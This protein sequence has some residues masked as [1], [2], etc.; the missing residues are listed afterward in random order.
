MTRKQLFSA[1]NELCRDLDNKY[2]INSGGCCYIAAIIA[3]N[4]EEYCIP[5]K[6]V[7]F[8][9]YGTHYAIMVSD[10]RLNGAKWPFRGFDEIVE[11]NSSRLFEIYYENEWNEVYSTEHNSEVNE[12]ISNLF[13]KYGNC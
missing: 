13:K 6:V 4:L 2:R 12:L 7:H 9:T 5:F 3:K 10:R 1:I 11:M 8:E